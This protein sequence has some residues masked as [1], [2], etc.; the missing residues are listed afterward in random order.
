MQYHYYD[1]L[2]QQYRE[3]L[4]VLHDVKRHI[5]AIEELYRNKENETAIEY[6]KNINDIIYSFEMNEFT[7]NRM[8]NIILN[9]KKRVAEQNNIAFLCKVDNI[10]LSFIDNI[11]LTTIFANL[12]D[13]AI[14]ACMGIVDEKKIIVQ[15]GAFNNLIMINIKNTVKVIPVIIGTDIKSSKENHNG[16]GLGNVTKVI[17]KYNGDFNIQFIDNMFECNIVV[18]K[19]GRI[20]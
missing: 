2:E 10:D 6:T 14:E 20:Q 19:Q 1:Y 15:V 18:S 11:D 7:D 9:D 17:N 3:S 16:L 5:W 13:N 8:L 4:S 12:L